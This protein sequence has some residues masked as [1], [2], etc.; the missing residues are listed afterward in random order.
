MGQSLDVRVCLRP[1]TTS[2]ETG[3]EHSDCTEIDCSTSR[4]FL[5]PRAADHK[6]RS[7]GSFAHLHLCNCDRCGS[8]LPL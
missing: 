5:F 2:K 6:Y 1:A 4:P 8:C 3:N 7:Q